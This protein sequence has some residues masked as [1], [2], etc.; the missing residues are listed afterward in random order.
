ML[1]VPKPDSLTQPYWD[2]V[3]QHELRIQKCRD[4]GHVWHP[5]LYNCPR[6]HSTH[7][8][9]VATSGHGVLYSYTIV[10]HA[11]HVAVADKVPYL[12]ALVTLAEGPR[13]VSNLLN[14]NPADA[15]IG[16]PL[17]LVFQEV[18]EGIW[19]PQFEPAAGDSAGDAT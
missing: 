3:R 18:A 4:C 15:R 14:C 9:W 19:L 7:V 11:A 17:R 6:C 12:V 13:V 2:G 5:P 8:D 1:I 16:M 10:H